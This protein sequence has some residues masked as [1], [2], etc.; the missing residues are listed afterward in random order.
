MFHYLFVVLP[1]VDVSLLPHYLPR[2][3]LVVVLP[4]LAAYF[5]LEVPIPITTFLIVHFIPVVELF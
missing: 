3:P 5:P 2:V 1:L 4:K